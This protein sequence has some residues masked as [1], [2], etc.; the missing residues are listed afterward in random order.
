M[1]SFLGINCH[2]DLAAGT[3]S[4][5]VASKIE[6]ML[7]DYDLQDLHGIDVPFNAELE[8]VN[9]D[10]TKGDETRKRHLAIIKD[11]FASLCGTCIYL[12]ITCRPD[13][14]TICNRACR[15]MHG[16]TE[17]QLLLLYYLLRYLRK[18]KQDALVYRKTGSAAQNSF[19]LLCSK[20]NELGNDLKSRPIVAYAD[21]DFADKHDARLRSTSGYC[22]FVFGN[23]VSWGSKRQSLTAKSTMAAELVSTTTASDEASFFYQAE[24]ELP[25]LFGTDSKQWTIPLLVD[26]RAAIIVANHPVTT[27]E[28]RHIALRE[29]RIRDFQDQSVV[30]VYW[31]PSEANLSD[32]MTKLMSRENFIR[33][34]KLIGVSVDGSAALCKFICDYDSYEYDAI[35]HC[36]Y[37]DDSEE[38]LIDYFPSS[39]LYEYRS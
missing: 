24:T 29:F 4:M 37:L 20:F 34:K 27:Q 15:G 36:S 28:S 32:N 26:N 23:L 7:E 12:S 1:D 38:T 9:P 25:F 3:F 14:A 31:C 10:L 22:I 39:F 13:I 30:R 6:Q 2:H 11:H 5:D 17:H 18:T 19:E 33:L 35:L 21:A 16:P 8:K